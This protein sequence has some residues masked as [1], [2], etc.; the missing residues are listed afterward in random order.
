MIEQTLIGDRL[1]YISSLGLIES[2]LNL[3]LN[4]ANKFEKKIPIKPVWCQIL[5]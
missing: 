4:F 2:M 1:G 5:V 3:K